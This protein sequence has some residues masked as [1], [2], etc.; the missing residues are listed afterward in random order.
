MPTGAAVGAVNGFALPMEPEADKGVIV[1]HGSSAVDRR[2]I[3]A[4]LLKAR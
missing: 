3:A 1:D 2:R 4:P